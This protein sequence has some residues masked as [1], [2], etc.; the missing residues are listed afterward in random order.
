MKEQPQLKDSNL[1]R[2]SNKREKTG[3]QVSLG[4]DATEPLKNFD[5]DNKAE[6]STIPTV[7]HG[8]EGADPLNF[9]NQ[10]PSLLQPLS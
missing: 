4:S 2:F 6:K 9:F 5:K 8:L 1:I 3:P 7:S 10:S